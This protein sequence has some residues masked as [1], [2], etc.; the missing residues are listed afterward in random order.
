M[1]LRNAGLT[2]AIGSLLVFLGGENMTLLSVATAFV[3]GISSSIM[4]NHPTV[5]MMSWVIRDLALPPSE[6]RHLALSAL[7]G[8]DL[9]PKML[10]IGS[11][12]AMLWFRILRSKGVDIPVSLYIM[13]G[14]PL[15]IA[16]VALSVLVLNAEYA[17]MQ[18]LAAH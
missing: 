6:T 1:G 4:N 8:G 3:A 2:Q 12:A 5:D 9:G 15:T 18:W 16:A 13:I 17:F 11:L 14:I 10:P 7:I